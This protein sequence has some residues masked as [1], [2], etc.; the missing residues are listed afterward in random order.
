MPILP[1]LDTSGSKTV[2]DVP[3]H[4][5]ALK[6]PDPVLR[7][8]AMP[9][10]DPAPANGFYAKAGFGYPLSPN[11]ELSYHNKQ[12]KN[13]KLGVNF[14]HFSSQGNITNQNFAKTHFDLGATYFTPKGIAAGAKFGFNLDANRFYG[15]NE[16]SRILPDSLDIFPDSIEVIKDSVSQRFFEFFGRISRSPLF[17]QSSRFRSIRPFLCIIDLNGT[18]SFH[19]TFHLRLEVR[20]LHHCFN[21]TFLPRSPFETLEFYVGGGFW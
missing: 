4:T 17:F 12:N 11:V 1:T 10:E 6:Y 7:P 13:L 2:Y 8:L 3:E 15:H 5:I 19:S 20:N 9:N 21:F 16:L 18:S 14:D